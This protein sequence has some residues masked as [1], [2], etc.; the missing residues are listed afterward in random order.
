MTVVVPVQDTRGASP[1]HPT[2]AEGELVVPVPA[3]A[4]LRDGGVAVVEEE[5]IELLDVLR[6][7][8]RQIDL[9][10]R[11][12]VV[13]ERVAGHAQGV[14]QRVEGLEAQALRKAPLDFGR[15]GR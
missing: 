13:A 10:P 11:R 5:A 6:H 2:S 12:D 8:A 3:H 7:R 4:M 1:E 15:P 9:R 14:G